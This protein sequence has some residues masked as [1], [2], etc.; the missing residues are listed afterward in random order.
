MLDNHTPRINMLEGQRQ[1]HHNRMDEMQDLLNKHKK[2]ISEL[3]EIKVNVKEDKKNGRKLE[4]KMKAID[5]SH[6][7]LLNQQ[8]SLESLV[9][10]YLP[11]KI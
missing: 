3:Y 9:E 5:M 6:G 2:D 10:K 8:I 11:L 1:H 7:T 4:K